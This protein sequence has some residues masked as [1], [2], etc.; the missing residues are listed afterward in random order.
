MWLKFLKD[1]NETRKKCLNIGMLMVTMIN[2]IDLVKSIIHTLIHFYSQMNNRQTSKI[3]CVK[4]NKI[5][6]KNKY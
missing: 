5:K 6:F 4:K 3:I 2:V 1:E